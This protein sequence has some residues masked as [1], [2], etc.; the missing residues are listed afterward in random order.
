[1]IKITTANAGTDVETAV[2]QA[3]Q[4]GTTGVENKSLA[5][6]HSSTLPLLKCHLVT[7]DHKFIGNEL[8]KTRVQSMPEYA[9]FPWGT[10]N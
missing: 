4:V 2:L 7:I 1:M 3:W 5:V 10:S 9:K 6:R 8:K